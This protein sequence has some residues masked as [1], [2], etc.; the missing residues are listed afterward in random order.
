MS[1]FDVIPV[2]REIGFLWRAVE[3]LLREMEGQH[4]MSQPFRDE[5]RALVEE[6][7][8]HRERRTPK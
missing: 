7:N 1:I 3:I 2:E 4:P 5:W 6:V 8:A